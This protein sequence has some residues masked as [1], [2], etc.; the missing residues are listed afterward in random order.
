MP[1]SFDL[2]KSYKNYYPK[3]NIDEA[4]S[5]ANKKTFIKL[6]RMKKEYLFLKNDPLFC[7]NSPNLRSS[8]KKQCKLQKRGQITEEWKELLQKENEKK[9]MKEKKQF[10]VYEKIMIKLKSISRF[11]IVFKK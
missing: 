6:K 11:L 8:T 2:L 5:E 9:K 4:I 1:L 3:N 10:N 7:S